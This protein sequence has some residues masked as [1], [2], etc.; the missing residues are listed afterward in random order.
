MA[1]SSIWPPWHGRRKSPQASGKLFVDSGRSAAGFPPAC[2]SAPCQTET[3]V[4]R[5]LRPRG[6][7]DAPE[8]IDGPSLEGLV[9]QHLRAL[10]QLRPG[11]ASLSFWRTRAGLEVDFG[12]YGP[13]LFLAI[14]VKRA[15][16]L[17][18]R[19]LAALRVFQEDY[20]EAQLLL[21]FIHPEPLVMDGTAVSWWNAGWGTCGLDP[22]KKGMG[23]KTRGWLI[24]IRKRHGK[25]FLREPSHGSTLCSREFFWADPR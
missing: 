24:L 8:E 12:L 19:D 4:F 17:H 10:C 22:V 15:A 16:R 3:G 21:L 1:A 20:P 23:G 2:F 25:P 6:P 11:G 7:L 5:S 13:D 9:A 14:E 18:H